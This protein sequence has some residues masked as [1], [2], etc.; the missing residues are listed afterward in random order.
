MN[1]RRSK[2]KAVM[3]IINRFRCRTTMHTIE[4]TL[5]TYI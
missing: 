5:C 3:D 1:W 2:I 4:A